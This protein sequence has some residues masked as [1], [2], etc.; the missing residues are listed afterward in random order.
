MSVLVSSAARVVR[1][2]AAICVAAVALAASGAA[3][4]ADQPIISLLRRLCIDTGGDA[5]KASA[6]ADALG[7]KAPAGGEMIGNWKVLRRKADASGDWALANGATALGDQ[8]LSQC[9]VIH[10]APAPTLKADVQA[11]L[12]FPPAGQSG[13]TM[14]F[15][16]IEKNGARVPVSGD[17]DEV[18]AKAVREGT[19]RMIVVTDD[20][21]ASMLTYGFP[22][23]K[24]H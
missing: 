19:F 4:A 5:V 10:K 8:P 15:G 1:Q 7:W 20:A 6:A 2:G 16:Y 13:P 11:W 18:V 14:V 24:S 9:M 3:H 21:T 23:P 17:A 12:G 22:T